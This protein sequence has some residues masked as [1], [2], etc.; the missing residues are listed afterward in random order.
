MSNYRCEINGVG[1]FVPENA[2]TNFDIE[3]MLDTSD[4]W[5]RQRTGI[6]KRHWADANVSTTDL[7]L[8]A[9]LEAIE[10]S[11]I[12]KEDID[13]IIFATLSPDHE[14]PGNGCFLQ[15]K[16][17]LKEIPAFDIRQQCSGFIYGLS[18][19]NCFIKSGQYKNI[20]LVGAEL[21][22]KGL[23]RTPKG[24]NVSVLF[25]DGA[26]A[27]IISRST[28]EDTNTDFLSFDLHAEGQYAKELWVSAPGYAINSSERITKEMLD[29]GLHYPHMNGRAVFTH[30][31]K[32]MSETLSNTLKKNNIK[33]EDVDLFLFHQ[34]NLRINDKVGEYMG[35]DSSKVFNTIQNYGNTTA[36][37]IP[38]GMRDAINA[39]KLKKGMTVGIAAF[40]AGFTWGSGVIRY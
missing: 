29:E 13:M 5:I 12:S 22:S 27:A 31:V 19:A 24:R 36:A 37:T 4:E 32:R 9:S 39:G 18:M 7:A 35:I 11:T 17:G 28:S 16:L 21:H 38:I 30:A 3:K 14:F 10:N 1:A 2:Y 20:L 8:N 6:E 25:G 23:D 26:G 15:H 33:T 40:G 34:A